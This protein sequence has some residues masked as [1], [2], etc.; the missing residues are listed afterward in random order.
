MKEYNV[1]EIGV[2][3]HYDDVDDSC[4]YVDCTIWLGIEKGINIKSISFDDNIYI[5]P[6]PYS[7][8]E[9][10]IDFIIEREDNTC[11]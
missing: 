2:P 7:M 8:K 6:I 10:P 1:Y 11:Q 9:A 5:K 3:D 4:P